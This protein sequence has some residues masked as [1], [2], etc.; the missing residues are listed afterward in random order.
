MLEEAKCTWRSGR[1]FTIIELLTVMSIIIILISVLVPALN[2]TRI[3]AKKV[4]QKGQFHEISKGLELFRNDHQ[5]TYP[6]SGAVDSNGLGYC[7]AMRLCEAL[8]GQDGMGYH[9]LS[10]FHSQQTDTYLFDLCIQTDPS[11]LSG[12]TADP[13]LVANLQERIK[14]IDVENVRSYRLQNIYNWDISAGVNFYPTKGAF[15]NT[16][17]NAV[18]GDVFQRATLLGAAT[19]M[20]CPQRAGQK[21]SMPVLYYK[22][23]PS[24][25][26]HDAVTQPAT[27]TPN[28]NIYNFDDN[29]AITALGC[30]WE[31]SRSS[32]HPMYLPANPGPLL[33]L[34]EITNTKI[35]S[36]PRPHNEDGYI[37]LSAGYDGLYGTKDDVF[38]F[39][40]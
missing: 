36:T 8:L 27:T 38:N 3:F 23:D 20:G 28:T 33:F 6:D 40:D 31:G 15:N 13:K 26:S 29:Y 19:P 35:T 21:A 25:L 9:P 24:K 17:P 37:L 11:L 5:D 1:G 34:R 16:Y 32:E 4:M 22:A 10:N 12:S 14:Y 2:K 7:G 30:P 18:I 39:T